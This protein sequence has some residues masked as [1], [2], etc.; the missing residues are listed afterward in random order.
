MRFSLKKRNSM[1]WKC[2]GAI[3]IIGFWFFRIERSCECWEQWCAAPPWRWAIQ[4]PKTDRCQKRGERAPSDVWRPRGDWIECVKVQLK[5]SLKRK[6]RD[7]CA[8]IRDRSLS[9]I[10]RVNFCIW[11]EILL[12]RLSRRSWRCLPIWRFGSN[13][14]EDKRGGFQKTIVRW[15][16]KM[17]F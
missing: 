7:G 15:R 6:S 3:M 5:W 4:S 11:T 12:W 1:L 8:F 10:W 14:E 13:S 16:S 2:N 9:P 17:I